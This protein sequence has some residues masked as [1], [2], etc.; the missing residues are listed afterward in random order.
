MLT[1]P[2]KAHC[3][4][5]GYHNGVSCRR[6]QCR[7]PRSAE[8]GVRAAHTANLSALETSTPI[9]WIA[10]LLLPVVAVYL[11]EARSQYHGSFPQTVKKTITGKTITGTTAS[12][13]FWLPTLLLSPSPSF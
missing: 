7:S 4:A 6:T 11:E 8:R 5:P 3:Q 2:N 9:P 13:A 12:D 1:N 10:P